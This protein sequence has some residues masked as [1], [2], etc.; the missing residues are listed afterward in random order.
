MPQPI[1]Q[2]TK[3]SLLP[4]LTS[5]AVAGCGAGTAPADEPERSPAGPQRSEPVALP[6]PV[7]G[8]KPAPAE[9]AAQPLE[10]VEVGGVEASMVG[11][12]AVV[13]DENGDQAGV[14]AVDRLT[15]DT[16]GV[17][18]PMHPSGD[19]D[20]GAITIRLTNGETACPD[21]ALTVDPLP[22]A[23]GSFTAAVDGLRVS[24]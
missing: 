12:Y 5:L 15:D 17:T 23:E 24:I 3:R 22:A 19:P 14:A 2:A 9:A 8:C 6:E 11:L 20:G 10:V 13:L 16:V 21:F 7:A 4:T 18:L 1:V